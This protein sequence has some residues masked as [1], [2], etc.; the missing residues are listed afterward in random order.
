MKSFRAVGKYM[1]I[2]ASATIHVL[3]TIS[4]HFQSVMWGT[5]GVISHV[6][7]ESQPTKGISRQLK[8][9]YSHLLTFLPHLLT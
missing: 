1:T 4:K 8:T 6:N 2:G 7:K 3:L 9:K 5:D